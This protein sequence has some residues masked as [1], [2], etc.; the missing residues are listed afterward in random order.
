MAVAGG[1]PLSETGFSSNKGVSSPPTS[2]PRTP[3]SQQLTL[4]G[5]SLLARLSCPPSTLMTAP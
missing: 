4:G 5:S 1:Y 3:W 2:V